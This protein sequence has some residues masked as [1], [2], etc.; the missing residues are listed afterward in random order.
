MSARTAFV[1]AMVSIVA[2]ERHVH[3]ERSSRRMAET[4]DMT[5]FRTKLRA[6][7][8]AMEAHP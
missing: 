2:S 1:A 6:R 5:D 3:E 7:A 8:R 4:T